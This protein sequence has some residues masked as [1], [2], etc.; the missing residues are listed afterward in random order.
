MFPIPPP[1][2]RKF[3][4]LQEF[5]IPYVGKNRCSEGRKEY[6]NKIIWIEQ[7]KNHKGPL[8]LG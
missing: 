1:G 4:F 2:G 7:P 5:W 3:Y 6:E 8:P